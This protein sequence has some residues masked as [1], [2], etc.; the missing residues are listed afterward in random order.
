MS[1]NGCNG[2]KDWKWQEWL[3]MAVNGLKLQEMIGMFGNDKTSLEMA[4]NGLKWL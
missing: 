3:Y 4:E 1:G 2:W